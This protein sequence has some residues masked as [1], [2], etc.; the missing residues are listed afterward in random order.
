MAK[1]PQ[2]KANPISEKLLSFDTFGEAFNFKLP[3][4]KDTYQTWLGTFFTLIVTLVLIFYGGLQI[5]RLAI[6]GETVVTMSVRDSNFSPEEVFPTEIELIHSD[7]NIAFGF[8]AYDS[9]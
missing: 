4:G 5:Q 9:E 7:F 1:K 6:Y 3:G 8:T 2:S